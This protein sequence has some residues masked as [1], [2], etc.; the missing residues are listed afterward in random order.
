MQI[1]QT[2]AKRHL[3]K[4]TDIRAFLKFFN[5]LSILVRKIL[6]KHLLTY[7]KIKS[8]VKQEFLLNTF[9]S[10]WRNPAKCNIQFAFFQHFPQLF[11]YSIKKVFKSFWFYIKYYFQSIYKS[12]LLFYSLNNYFFK[13]SN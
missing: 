11:C 4:F 12:D 10:Q 13:T 3:T 6:L 1:R 2:P 7:H 5:T 8:L 9:R